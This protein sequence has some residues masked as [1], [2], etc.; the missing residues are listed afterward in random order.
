MSDDHREPWS[1]FI[2]KTLAASAIAVLFAFVQ[3]LFQNKIE[4]NSIKRK[5]EI[6]CKVS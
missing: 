4:E 5:E 2:I 1:S 3:F 6:A